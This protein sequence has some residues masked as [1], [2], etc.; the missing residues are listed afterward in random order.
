MI[1]GFPTDIGLIYEG[2]RI[3]KANTFVDLGG[4]KSSVSVEL[5]RVVPTSKV[6]DGKVTVVGPEISKMKEGSVV[7][8]GVLVEVA[9]KKLD[10]DLEGVFE[11]K[12]H[13]FENYIQGFM[14][15]NSRD[16]IWCRMNKDAQKAGLTL[17]DVGN[18]IITLFRNEFSVIEKI[19]VTFYTDE[20][21]AKKF[22]EE[23]REVYKKRDERLL[24]LSDEDV[25]VFYNCALCQSFAPEHVCTISPDRTGLC[26]SVSWF[27]G[28]ASV[29]IDPK[30]SISECPKGELIDAENY[31]YA[32]VNKN[33]N[34]KSGGAIQ[35]VYMHS[36]FGHPQSSCGCFEA[37]AFYIPEADALGVVH[38]DFKGMTPFGIPFSTL[39]SQVG[40][41]KQ[42]EGFC[43]IAIEYMRSPKFLVTDGGWNRVVWVPKVI[44]D[45]FYEV[46]PEEVR[47]KVA[48]EEDA[49]DIE[50][51]KAFLKKKDHPV[52]KTW[53]EEEEKPVAE[54]SE[55]EVPMSGVAV[56]G[57]GVS[58]VF[59]NAKIYAE[60]VVIT[61][62]DKK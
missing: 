14:H 56:G 45:R 31:E 55:L 37:I 36:L 24:S 52:V 48:T 5:L 17:K 50:S 42:T 57:G 27:E 49:Q 18:A 9:G 16:I 7:P 34:D 19:Q 46:I 30:G 44:K 26:G 20:K 47:D 51:L 61:R 23:A 62:K 6:Q 3:R 15:L 35:R 40:G 21:E 33:A 22:L 8:F 2:E 43:G 12:L 4:P 10:E 58:I 54:V 53:K 32:G 59:K 28:R 25:E 38:R 41:G 60:K 29:Q 39:A 13:Y 11:R 1:K